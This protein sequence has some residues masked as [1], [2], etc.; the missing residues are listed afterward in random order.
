MHTCSNAQH[1]HNMHIHTTCTHANSIAKPGNRCACGLVSCAVLCCGVQCRLVCW[2]VA[3]CHLDMRTHPV[4]HV[5]L[6]SQFA[7]R[8]CAHVTHVLCMGAW[9]HVVRMCCLCARLHLVWCTLCMCCACVQVRM[10]FICC[11][12]VY[13]YAVQLVVSTTQV[14]ARGWE[15]MHS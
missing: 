8:R 5:T 4:Q 3:V 15:R 13:I 1:M 12:G 9:L 6:T 14:A 7:S 2:C 10:L 11:A